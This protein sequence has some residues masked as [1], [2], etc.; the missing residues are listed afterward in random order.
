MKCICCS[1]S[2]FKKTLHRTNPI[3]SKDA[4]WMCINCIEK[5]EPELSKDIKMDGYNIIQDIK[6][7]SQNL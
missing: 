1:A 2:V 4:G 3:G 6:K 7:A 5:I